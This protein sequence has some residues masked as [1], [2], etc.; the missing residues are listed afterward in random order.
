MNNK[1]LKIAVTGGI[2][3]GKSEFCSYL[4]AKGYPVLYADDI[5]KDVLK[6]NQ[7][8]KDRIISAFGRKSFT[9]SK[10]DTKYLAEVVFSDPGNVKKINSIIHPYVIKKQNILMNDLLKENDIVFLEAALIYEAEIENSFDYVVLIYTEEKKKIE[11]AQKRSKLSGTEV[12]KIIQN[13]IPDEVK[14]EWADFVF[15]NNSNL[16]EL[17]NKADLFINIITSIRKVH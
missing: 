11:R 12:R 5:A 9:D 16:T 10:P 1:K 14:K 8:V 13:Q 6:N 7:K 4:K 15:E 17:K 3:S 2:G